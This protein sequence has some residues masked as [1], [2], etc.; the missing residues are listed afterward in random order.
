MECSFSRAATAVCCAARLC[1]GSVLCT[2]YLDRRRGHLSCRPP[3]SLD[4][5]SHVLWP[6]MRKAAVSVLVCARMDGCGR[7]G[8]QCQDPPQCKCSWA[9]HVLRQRPASRPHLMPPCCISTALSSRPPG[10]GGLAR[11]H[12]AA[13][14]QVGEVGWSRLTRW[15]GARYCRPDGSLHV[16]HWQVYNLVSTERG[17]RVIRASTHAARY[18]HSQGRTQSHS[19]LRP[20]FSLRT[21]LLV[22][23]CVCEHG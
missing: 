13:K 18:S 20:F 21:L 12:Q 9:L 5:P 19:V 6:A 4:W 7:V 23:T 17:C 11:E 1:S 8:G 16:A 3:L 15:V 10:V 14:R 2:T 22:M